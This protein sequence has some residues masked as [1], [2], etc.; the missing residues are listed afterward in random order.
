[1]SRGSKNTELL[2]REELKGRAWEISVIIVTIVIIV[3]TAFI[4]TSF[5]IVIIVTC[6]KIVI[7]VTSVTI[8]I[9]VTSLII[10]IIVAIDIDIIVTNLTIVIIVTRVWPMLSL[11]PI[12]LFNHSQ[13]DHS[14][15]CDQC[16][17][18]GQQLIIYSTTAK[19]SQFKLN[20]VFKGSKM[21][22]YL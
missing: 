5:T 1:M 6:L 17:H 22:L 12:L 4:V 10:V 19:K 2:G 15:H 7:I 9:I 14:D 8:E 16:E 13:F 11:W 20:G 18:L 21:M 3:T